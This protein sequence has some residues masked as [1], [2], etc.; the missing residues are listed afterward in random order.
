LIKPAI[1]SWIEWYGF[2]SFYAKLDKHFTRMTDD[3]DES[4]RYNEKYPD[5]LFIDSVRALDVASTQN[6]ADE[7]G[8][9]YDLAYR[10][11]KQLEDESRVKHQKVGS[12][13]VWLI[14]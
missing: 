11:M 8:C 6:I 1:Q 4:G 7:V 3:R 13:F 2:L 9:S 10:R 12:A 5:E 14:F